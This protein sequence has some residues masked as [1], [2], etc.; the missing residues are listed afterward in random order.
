M[1]AKFYDIFRKHAVLLLQN[2]K[3]LILNPSLTTVFPYNSII[4]SPV[5]TAW[6]VLKLRMEERPPILRVVA[7]ILNKQSRTGDKGFSS[8]FGVGRG[9]KI[10]SP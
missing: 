1:W 7:N 9:A 5:T 3:R 10:S 4:Y 6:L 8:D 2:M